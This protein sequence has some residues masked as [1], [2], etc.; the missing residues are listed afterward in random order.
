MPQ[1]SRSFDPIYDPLFT[2]SGAKDHYKAQSRAG[3]GY[4]VGKQPNYPNMF[5]DVPNYPATQFSFKPD[6]AVPA[7]VDRTYHPSTMPASELAAR[8]TDAQ[9]TGKYQALFFK[10]PSLPP[11]VHPS[12]GMLA[13]ARRAK[14]DPEHKPVLSASP[15]DSPKGPRTVG[16]QTDYRESETQTAPYTPDVILK[17]GEPVPEVMLLQHLTFGQGLP[18]GQAEMEMIDK[19]REKVS[20]EASLPPLD[21][22][23]NILL[24]RKMMDKFEHKEFKEREA[25]IRQLQEERLGVLQRQLEAREAENEEESYRRIEALRNERLAAKQAVFAAIQKRRIK[26]LRKLSKARDNVEKKPE[27][28][29]LIAD[30]A[31]SASKVYAPKTMMGR[32]PEGKLAGV[33]INP[34]PYAPKNL[35]DLTS[36]ET[37]MPAGTL[38]PNTRRPV[39]PATRNAAQRAQALISSRLNHIDNL[40]QTT[41]ELAGGA[42]GIGECWPAP[43][44]A[45][46]LSGT[47]ARKRTLRAPERPETPQLEPPPANAAL[48][49][50]VTLLQRLL[51]GRAVQN[52]MFLGKAAAS[53]L[54]AELRC[55]GGDAPMLVEVGGLPGDGSGGGEEGE[56]GLPAHVR[57]ARA[58]DERREKARAKEGDARWV[59]GEGGA[60]VTASTETET[61]L[62]MMDEEGVEEGLPRVD[63]EEGNEGSSGVGQQRRTSVTRFVRSE[64]ATQGDAY[65]DPLVEEPGTSEQVDAAAG[66]DG[67]MGTEGGGEGEEGSGTPDHSQV[68]VD[69]S[70]VPVPVSVSEAG[71]RRVGAD[72]DREAAIRTIQ[73]RARGY[74]ARKQVAT[75]KADLRLLQA[76]SNMSPQERSAF[77]RV[78]AHARGRLL[79]R[80]H[81]H[82]K[83]RMASQ[84][85]EGLGGMPFLDESRTLESREAK[86]GGAAAMDND[87]ASSTVDEMERQLA[88]LEA[89]GDLTDADALLAEKMQAQI[90]QELM[91]QQADAM[92]QEIAAINRLDRFNEADHRSIV[93]IQANI[94]GYLTRKQHHVVRRR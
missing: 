52:T 81:P 91:R 40:L 10:R 31:N 2:V 73:A 14:A 37:G 22:E 20:F 45:D 79:R 51:R 62:R 67:A 86:R 54:I 85:E 42:R 66:E 82:R 74:L 92:R 47:A 29:D 60:V 83:T 58:L 93:A 25:E 48:L 21:T 71:I 18:A 1:P 59:Q 53:E 38:R 44:D 36:L 61:D 30:Y 11:G 15:R 78:Q 24:W 5:S 3:I 94:R 77:I 46:G 90:R 41:K 84:P 35:D 39:P 32:F 13:L 76:W 23:E 88:A 65:H 26:E 6:S 68:G 55:G 64:A 7:F 69:P 33:D 72:A 63:A 57:A 4:K 9:V 43:L 8:S 56:A 19:I 75:M 27:K 89:K 49:A 50:A 87:A 28:R 16:T 80:K 34:T 17:E 70:P 12:I